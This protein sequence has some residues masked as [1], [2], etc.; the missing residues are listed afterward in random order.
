MPKV[1]WVCRIGYVANFIRFPTAQKFT[2]SLKVGTFLRHSVVLT[3]TLNWWLELINGLFVMSK[4][5][6]YYSH[7]YYNVN[8]S[9][10]AIKCDIWYAHKTG[11]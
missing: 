9:F 8:G 3:S 2:E 10:D 4:L 7:T 1:W 5:I 11:V 6:V